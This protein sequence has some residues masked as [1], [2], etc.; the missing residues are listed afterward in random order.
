MTP[1]S[2]VPPPATQKVPGRGAPAPGCSVPR[3]PP[4]RV[5]LG[6][7]VPPVGTTEPVMWCPCPQDGGRRVPM[8]RE[9]QGRVVW[10]TEGGSQAVWGFW[11]DALG[12]HGRGQ[13][14]YR[15]S[16]S[17]LCRAWH[18]SPRARSARCCSV[19]SSS[20]CRSPR[21]CSS[22]RASSA[23]GPRGQRGHPDTPNPPGTVP[24]GRAAV[25]PLVWRDGGFVPNAA[26]PWGWTDGCRG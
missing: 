11:G 23:V 13:G 25:G 14:P 7:I 17:S 3:P 4:Q 2:A 8:G 22:P 19:T 1:S 10:G 26:A 5:Q 9:G 16:S 24:K 6:G 15:V 20:R 12:W 21:A 18:C